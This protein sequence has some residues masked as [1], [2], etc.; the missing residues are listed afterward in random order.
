MFAQNLSIDSFASFVLASI[1]NIWVPF[2][3][4]KYDVSQ[5]FQNENFCDEINDRS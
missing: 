2:Y 5:M 4:H 1:F 3:L